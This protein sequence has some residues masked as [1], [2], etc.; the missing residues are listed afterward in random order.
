MIYFPF[1]NVP[2]QKELELFKILRNNSAVGNLIPNLGG[3]VN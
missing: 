1:D 3:F 2:D